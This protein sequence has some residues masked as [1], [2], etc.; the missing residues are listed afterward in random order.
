MIV[1]VL[2]LMVAQAVS[3]QGPDLTI[4]LAHESEG[5]RKTREQLERLL[6]RF[7][8]ERWIE[9]R[10]VVIDE[11]TTPHSHPVLTLHTRHFDSDLQLMS[12][13]V[14]EQF[15]WYVNRER[16]RRD[17]AMAAFREHY[18]DVPV[19]G[20][21]GARDA[22]STYLHLVVCDLEFQA[23][24]ILVG[25]DEAKRILE[26]FTHYEWIYERVLEDPFVRSV[27][28]RYQLILR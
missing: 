6:S 22:Q 16:E 20:S 13:F 26:R 9:T 23:M 1:P 12:T 19:G 10:E 5:E 14:H 21:A 17:S 27:M 25:R 11:R 3:G 7:D 15:H 2:L 24:T 4:R 8:V 18:P 28:T